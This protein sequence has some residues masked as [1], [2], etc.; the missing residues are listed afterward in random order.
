MYI[1]KTLTLF[2]RGHSLFT[3][4]RD[5][6]KNTHTHK[7][8]NNQTI[9]NNDGPKTHKHKETIKQTNKKQQ[10]QQTIGRGLNFSDIQ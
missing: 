4:R 1:K 2:C 5:G 7:T 8:S 10:H 9:K 6:P 3:R